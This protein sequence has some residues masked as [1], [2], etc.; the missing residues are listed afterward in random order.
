MISSYLTSMALIEDRKSGIWNRAL[1]AGA[2]P[3]HFLVSHLIIGSLLMIIQAAEFITYAFYVG[4]DTHRWSFIWLVSSLIVMLGFCGTL[5]GLCISVLT[6]SNLVATY[7]SIIV[8]YP[9]LSLSGEF[10]NQNVLRWMK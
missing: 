7:F 5:Y 8:T 6:D 9:F 4:T 3:N 1:T 2:K 10:H